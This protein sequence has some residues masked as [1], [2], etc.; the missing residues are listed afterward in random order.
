MLRLRPYKPSDSEYILR[1]WEDQPEEEF[2]KWSAGKFLYPL[3]RE[4]LERY[5]E[6]WCAN[7][8]SGW[9]MAALDDAGRVIGHLLM[10]LANFEDNSLR[11][12]FIVVDPRLRGKGYGVQMISLALKYAFEILGVKR[13]SLG[14]FEN[15][16][17]ARKCYEAAGFR[18]T[19]YDPD[20]FDY[21]GKS[22]G[23]I[24]MEAVKP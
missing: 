5:H 14:V 4:E 11:F 9:P 2:T 18:E 22:W 15:N 24:E 17:A 1:W 21:H 3:N 19:G 6:D 8:T 20:Y 7:E 12:G 13:V 10:R 23:C 16:P